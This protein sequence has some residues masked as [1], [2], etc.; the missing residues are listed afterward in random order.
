MNPS[1][2][3]PTLNSMKTL[4]G[5][6]QELIQ[7]QEEQLNF[8]EEKMKNIRELISNYESGSIPTPKEYYD[9]L[10]KESKEKVPNI[11]KYHQFIENNGAEKFT[12]LYIECCTEYVPNFR[13]FTYTLD[14]E[15]IKDKI[16]SDITS[17][18]QDLTK[19]LYL[20]Y[21]PLLPPTIIINAIAILHQDLGKEF[22]DK[23][24]LMI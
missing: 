9:T 6:Q 21:M 8:H 2:A 24:D 22:F 19:Q 11:D 7:L 23:L 10:V 3:S 16:E 5:K 14:N 15:I 13:E 1:N 4:I 20:D 12:Q 18:E 17:R